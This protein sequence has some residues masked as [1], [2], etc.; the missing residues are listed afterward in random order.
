MAIKALKQSVSISET[1]KMIHQWKRRK[2][3]T[4]SA[5]TETAGSLLGTDTAY[6]NC[7]KEYI[8]MLQP[9]PNLPVH[10]NSRIPYTPVLE[11]I[12]DK[13]LAHSASSGTKTVHQPAWHFTPRCGAIGLKNAS[14]QAAGSVAELTVS[15]CQSGNYSCKIKQLRIIVYYIILIIYIPPEDSRK[16]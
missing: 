1:Q 8:R 11:N 12:S 2:E 14:A 9:L 16:G 3:C 4:D 10:D 7:S 15:C 5:I 6:M 13:L